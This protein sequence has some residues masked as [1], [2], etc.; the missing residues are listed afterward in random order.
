MLRRLTLPI[1][2]I[3][4]S[5]FSEKFLPNVSGCSPN[6]GVRIITQS[7]ASAGLHTSSVRQL[8]RHD[9]GG[10]GR[11]KPKEMTAGGENSSILEIRTSRIDDR[12][13]DLQLPT[14]V[15]NG[16]MFK[17]LPIV[18]VKASMNN[19]IMTVTDVAGAVSL[20][21]ACGYDGFKNARKGTNVAAQA[22]AFTLGKKMVQR[23]FKTVRARVQGLGP[24]R[25]ASLKGLTLA[26]V[27][28]VSIT[29]N[30]PVSWNPPR[31]RKQRRL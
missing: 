13:P 22:T 4:E 9:R 5:A 20:I 31:A 26:G 8:G 2:A 21:R 14:R 19:T 16:I 27:D 25:L 6:S 28:V 7:F 3:V 10:E 1:R 29:D 18:N 15:F 17:D 12:F 23:G 24:G 30:T 11:Y